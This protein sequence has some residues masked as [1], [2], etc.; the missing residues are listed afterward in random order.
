MQ[1]FACDSNSIRFLSESSP[2]KYELL[3]FSYSQ[4]IFTTL[5]RNIKAFISF[6]VIEKSHVHFLGSP[7]LIIGE[8]RQLF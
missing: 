6:S 1:S 4:F 8:Y 7:V 3:I 2:S 5:Q